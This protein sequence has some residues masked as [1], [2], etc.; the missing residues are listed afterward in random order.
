MQSPVHVFFYL[1]LVSRTT[2]WNQGKILIGLKHQG[3]SP[4]SLRIVNL[5]KDSLYFNIFEEKRSNGMFNI[6]GEEKHSRREVIK[7]S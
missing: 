7:Y 1:L 2:V 4:F 6:F 5:T 3:L